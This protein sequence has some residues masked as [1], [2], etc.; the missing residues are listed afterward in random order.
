M[1]LKILLAED[2]TELRET[3][4]DALEFEGMAVR[5]CDCAETAIAAAQ[6]ERFDIALL[7]LVMPGMTGIEA[8]T[9]LK[10]IQPDMGLVLTTAFATVDTAVEAMK[11][12]ADEFLTKPFNLEALATTLRR[13]QAQRQTQP[14]FA[15]E[16]ADKIFAALSNPIRRQALLHLSHHAP[17]RFMDLCRKVGIEDHTKFNF[18]LRQLKQSGLLQ[19]NVNKLYILTNKGRQMCQLLAGE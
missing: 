15:D 18:H 14:Q 16:E 19:Q 17:M 13:V 5:A 12:G 10:Q 2:D 3:L 8:Q 6:Q 4:V 1:T 9:A 7:D 11:K